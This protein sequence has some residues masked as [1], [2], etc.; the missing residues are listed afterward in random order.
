MSP[1]I[2]VLRK[3]AAPPII[4][5][6]KPYGQAVEKQDLDPV[7]ILF[8]EYEAMRLSDNSQLNHHQA[9]LMMGISR[10]TF[11]RIYASAL[12]K[13]AKAFV[14]GR[15]IT[16]KNGKVNFDHNWYQCGTCKSYF[17][18]PQEDKKVENCTLCGSPEFNE[19]NTTDKDEHKE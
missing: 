7:N 12:Q 15:P 16:I 11:T 4:D 3:V 9:S 10:P 18:P 19:L 2:K 17:N 1:R 13:V 8:E 6:F 14:E 5:G